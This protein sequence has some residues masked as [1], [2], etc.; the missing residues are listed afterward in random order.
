MLDCRWAP[1]TLFRLDGESD[2]LKASNAGL[3]LPAAPPPPS[4]HGESA[5]APGTALHVGGHV[6]S[7]RPGLR[8][9]LGQGAAWHAVQAAHR[10]RV[11]AVP[12]DVL[13]QGAKAAAE[14]VLEE[15]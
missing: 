8:Q 12:L 11:A 2:R 1:A 13:Q 6:H 9:G 5:H 3:G 10:H 15:R 14:R 7:H 4:A